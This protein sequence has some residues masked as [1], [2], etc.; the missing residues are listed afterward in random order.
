MRKFAGLLVLL[1]LLGLAGAPAF[2]GGRDP[3]ILIALDGFRAEYLDRSETPNLAA[4]GA[5]GVRAEAM[6]PSFPSVTN[7]NHYTLLTGLYP[8]HHGVVDN[9]MKDPALPGLWFGGTEAGKDDADPRWWDGATPIW[10]TAQRA[11]LKT[12]SDGWPHDWVVIKGQ[13]PTY[14]EPRN[15]S[16]HVAAQVDRVLSWLDLPA[17][18]RPDFIRLHLDPTDAIGHLFG[19]DAA[20]TN[21]AIRQADGAVGRLVTGLKSRGLYDKVNLIIVSDHGMTEVG[22][23]RTFKLADFVD[24]K[25]VDVSTFGSDMGVTPMPGHEAEVEKA[26]LGRHPHL[27]C[28]K[29]AEIPAHLHYRDSPRIPPIFCLPDLGWLVVTPQGEKLYGGL[30]GDH[31]FD[32]NDPDMWAIFL[33]HGPG[34][35]PGARLS[36]FDNVDVYPMMARLLGV[37]PEPN[38]GRLAEVAGALR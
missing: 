21:A 19:P 35:R 33:A 1:L 29:R 13:V 2:A 30:R 37:K 24:P 27:S 11:G 31:G 25:S 12:A 28:W 3:L 10:I 18:R 36:V 34:F 23:A 38:D 8:E 26:L 5:E 32:P 4:L 22:P 14:I 16:A 17:D 15:P 6:R 20:P 7:P 9:M